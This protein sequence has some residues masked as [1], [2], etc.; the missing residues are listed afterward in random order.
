MLSVRPSCQPFSHTLCFPCCRTLFFSHTLCIQSHPVPSML[1]HPVFQSHPVHPCTPCR[2]FLAENRKM[3]TDLALVAI[4]EKER[5]V[6]RQRVCDQREEAVEATESQL[7]ERSE[8]AAAEAATR[9]YNLQVER[10]ELSVTPLCCQSR[11]PATQ[12][13]HTLFLQS[14]PLHSV[15]PSCC[16]TLCFQSGHTL[17]ILSRPLAVAPSVSSRG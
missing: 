14:H 6:K 16:H 8:M 7:A 2:A 1:S 17:C 5:V 15:T 9:M 12:C 4:E 11:H 10:E 3:A 13:C